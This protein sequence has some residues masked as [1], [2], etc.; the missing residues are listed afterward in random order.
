MAQPTGRQLTGGLQG[1]LHVEAGL[2]VGAKDAEVALGVLQ[3]RAAQPSIEADHR[4]ERAGVDGEAEAL[5][6]GVDGREGDERQSAGDLVVLLRGGVAR[7]PA[8]LHRV[9]VV[10]P[11][12]AVEARPRPVVVHRA[13]GVQE[14]PDADG[15]RAVHRAFAVSLP[16]GAVPVRVY[17]RVFI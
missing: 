17:I 6:A 15:R 13:T 9:V 5:V 16:F 3:A 10:A 14:D 7:A 4:G 1:E 2:R 12:S 8:R 11:R